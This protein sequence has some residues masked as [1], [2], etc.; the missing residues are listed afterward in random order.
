MHALN[1]QILGSK[2]YNIYP[3]FNFIRYSDS[4]F[5]SRRRL[6]TDFSH[7]SRNRTRT[8]SGSDH[9]KHVESIIKGTTT[10]TDF[11]NNTIEEKA[12]LLKDGSYNWKKVFLDLGLWIKRWRVTCFKRTKKAVDNLGRDSTFAVVTFT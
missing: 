7:Y 6:N 12:G 11:N 2:Q 8:E 1:L 10:V 3:D 5:M 9:W 4:S